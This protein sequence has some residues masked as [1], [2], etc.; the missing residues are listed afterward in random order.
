MGWEIRPRGR[1]A[2]VVSGSAL[3]MPLGRMTYRSCSR[4][5]ADGG[6]AAPRLCLDLSLRTGV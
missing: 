5:C 2:A 6:R 4:C 3:T 1:G